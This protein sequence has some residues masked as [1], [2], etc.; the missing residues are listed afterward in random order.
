MVRY[1]HA[2]FPSHLNLNFSLSSG[3]SPEI[4]STVDISEADKMKD[5]VQV[6]LY[7]KTNPTFD[8]T[9]SFRKV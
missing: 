1:C 4:K 6:Q 5:K 9:A 7:Y 8:L 3:K 2:S